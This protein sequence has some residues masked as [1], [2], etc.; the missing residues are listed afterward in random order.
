MQDCV[1]EIRVGWF[2]QYNLIYIVQFAWVICSLYL[3]KCTCICLLYIYCSALFINVC[4][5]LE[6]ISSLWNTY[7]VCFYQSKFWNLYIYIL[8]KTIIHTHIHTYIQIYIHKMYIL[9]RFFYQ[10]LNVKF[11]VRYSFFE[12]I[13]VIILKIR[14]YTCF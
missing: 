7:C 12:F 6:R 8:L 14:L 9:N 11:Y 1:C 4:I 5:V 3:P 2:V 13:V 10:I